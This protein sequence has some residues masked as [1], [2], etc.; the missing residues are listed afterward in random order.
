LSVLNPA[1]L[2]VQN[3]ERHHQPEPSDGF[4]QSES[5]KCVREQLTKKRRISCNRRNK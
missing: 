3:Q 1:S 2:A 4:R 5:K